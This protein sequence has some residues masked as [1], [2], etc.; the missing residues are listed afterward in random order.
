MSGWNQCEIE[1]LRKA[2]LLVVISKDEETALRHRGL[3]NI[4]WSP[5]LVHPSNFSLTERVGLI[6]SANLFNQ[7][8]LRW[9]KQ[10][11][12]PA[13]LPLTIYGAL[14]QFAGWPEAKRIAHYAV[15]QQPYQECGIILLPTAS[16]TGVQIKV[17]EALAAGRAVVARKGAM[18]GLPPGE[19]AWLEVDSP[20]AMWAQAARLSKD[21]Q[22]RTRQ[23]A[24]AEAYYQ[25][26][27][28]ADKILTK[29]RTVY[30][31]LAARK[32]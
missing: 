15:S 3:R 31:E 27:L 19:G 24:K 13:S 30:A 1:E 21:A 18:R 23:A 32:R 6:G 8:G 22:L 9:L 28:Q 29:L 17:V 16:G 11:A 25:E 20:E 14:A 5:P 7:E 12:K 4:L 26:H 2:D 10:A